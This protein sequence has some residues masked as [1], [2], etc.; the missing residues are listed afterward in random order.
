M[1]RAETPALPKQNRYVLRLRNVEVVTLFKVWMLSLNKLTYWNLWERP[2]F[3]H[4][5][6]KVE[7]YKLF[8]L[9]KQLT[10]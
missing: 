3:P 8:K 6:W 7:L 9:E 4:A 5:V 10:L 2:V 1:C